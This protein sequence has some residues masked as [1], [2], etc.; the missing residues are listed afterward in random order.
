MSLN[1]DNTVGRK[2]QEMFLYQQRANKIILDVVDNLV[3]QLGQTQQALKQLT[4]EKSK[5]KNVKN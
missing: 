3:A 4:E 2:L 5:A 1:P